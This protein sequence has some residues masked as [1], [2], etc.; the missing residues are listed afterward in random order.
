MT[1]KTRVAVSGAPGGI[2]G[3]VTPSG[4]V[5][6]DSNGMTLYTLLT[7]GPCVDRCLDT[8]TP[9]T[10]PMAAIQ[11]GDWTLLARTDGAIQ[12]AHKGLALYGC[13]NDAVPGDTQCEGPEHGGGRAVRLPAEETASA[14]G[15][16]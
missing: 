3:Q 10:A 6:A 7:T 15:G 2:V 13:T 14:G 12:W 16:R 5:L 4:A 11:T 9:L 8:W 1:P